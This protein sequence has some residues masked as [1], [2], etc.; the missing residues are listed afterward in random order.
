MPK[1]ISPKSL[2]GRAMAIGAGVVAFFSEIDN[3]KKDAKIE[4]M[5]KRITDLEQKET[6]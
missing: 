4:E 1:K 6:L 3:Q 5:E 2:I